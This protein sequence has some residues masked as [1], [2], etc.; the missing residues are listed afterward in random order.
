MEDNKK[1]NHEEQENGCGLIVALVILI[2]ALY[3]LIRK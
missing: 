2:W 3:Y 1:Y